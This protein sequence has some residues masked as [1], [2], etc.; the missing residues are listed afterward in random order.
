[1]K[2]ICVLILIYASSCAP[3]LQVKQVRVKRK[4]DHKKER[5]TN[6]YLPLIG[7]ACLSAWVIDRMDGD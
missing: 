6:N 2:K 3:D 4:A 7:I 5:P 1:M